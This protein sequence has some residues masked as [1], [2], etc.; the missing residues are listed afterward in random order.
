MENQEQN[1]FDVFLEKTKD[2]AQ[3]VE[4]LSKSLLADQEARKQEAE[5][6][7]SELDA[8]IELK[9]SEAVAKSEA[10]EKEIAMLKSQMNFAKYS[11]I[12]HASPSEKVLMKSE[13]KDGLNSYFEKASTLRGGASIRLDSDTSKE[14]GNY[15]VSSWL[16][17]S[18]S[19]Y[20][21]DSNA[22]GGYL[23][24]PTILPITNQTNYTNTEKLF[25][26]IGVSQTVET[27]AVKMPQYVY[28]Y[29]TETSRVQARSEGEA[30]SYDNAEGFLKLQTVNLE[31]LSYGKRMSRDFV[32]LNPQGYNFIISEYERNIRRRVSENLIKTTA[33]SV[34]L[35]NIDNIPVVMASKLPDNVKETAGSIQ[36]ILN[37]IVVEM[38]TVTTLRPDRIM[39]PMFILNRTLI[40]KLMFAYNNYQY[41]NLVAGILNPIN[42]TILTAEF[43]AVPYISI[44]D[45][46][47][48]KDSTGGEVSCI[49]MDAD[50]YKIFVNPLLSEFT[51]Q[52]PH[53]NHV[54]NEVANLMTMSIASKLIDVNR[55]VVLKVKP[56]SQ[57]A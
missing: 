39:K 6:R 45:E 20:S 55:V 2:M 7:K 16:E 38:M 46:N 56:E 27:T 17:K 42:R 51:S 21:N 19:G 8:Q 15:I 37:D 28:D 41:H 54:N 40:S 32:K 14:L 44:A 50:A 1:K 25:D 52:D 49:F 36:T 24:Q 43:G 34:G 22:Y 30:Y 5:L 18:A 47:L 13:T 3:S 33:G 9:K 29:E 11:G 10:Q 12:S 53:I 26:L 35:K 4:M 57:Q 23:Q 31:Q 48:L